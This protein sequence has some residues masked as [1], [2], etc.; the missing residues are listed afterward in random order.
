[1]R[2]HGSILCRALCHIFPFGVQCKIYSASARALVQVLIFNYFRLQNRFYVFFCIWFFTFSADV[3]SNSDK[4]LFG[5]K[6]P[7]MQSYLIS[8]EDEPYQRYS[9]LLPAILFLSMFCTMLRLKYQDFESIA[10]VKGVLVFSQLFYL[11]A[12]FVKC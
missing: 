6:W 8:H 1:M 10:I 3:L 2:N 12:C 7:L 11:S 5:S 9:I 4:A